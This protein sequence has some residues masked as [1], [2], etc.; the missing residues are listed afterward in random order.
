MKQTLLGQVARVMVAPDPDSLRS[1]ALPQVRVTFAGF[2]GDR[3]A[4]LTMRSGGRTPHYPRGM[5]IRNTRQISLVSVEELDGIAAA[6]NIPELL[7]E[8]LGANLL[9]R[10]IPRLSFLPPGTRLFFPQDAVLVVEGENHPC[11]TA[12]QS[13]QAA[14]PAIPKLASA[15]PKAGLHR[16]G[17]V[18]WVERPGVIAAGD[19]VR[20]HVPPQRLYAVPSE[21]AE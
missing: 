12:G 7:P 8:W 16:R 17:L 19:S 21:L 6:L 15:F 10:G 1:R 3:H 11:T 18:G 20:V 9:L 4:G 13:I 2:E 14:Y 5:E